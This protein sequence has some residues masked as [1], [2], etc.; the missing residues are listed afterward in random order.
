LAR[1]SLGSSQAR[2]IGA[3]ALVGLVTLGALTA[4][5]EP[6]QSKVA[7]N[8]AGL[9]TTVGAVGIR[10]AQVTLGS[11]GTAIVTMALF[12]TGGSADALTT[13]SSDNATGAEIPDGEISLPDSD[14][15]FIN[16]KDPVLLTGMKPV[17]VGANISVTVGFEN[18]GT[19]TLRLPITGS[20]NSIVAPSPTATSSSTS[21]ARTSVL[22]MDPDGNRSRGRGQRGPVLL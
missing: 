16:A 14:G 17:L 6:A 1:P 8:T 9:N 12:N 11:D 21:R 15:V 20:D 10:N 13:V 5:R 7:S 22:S 19:V 2:S 18:A 3:F 4:C